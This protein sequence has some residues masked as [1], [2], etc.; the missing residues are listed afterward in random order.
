MAIAPT[1]VKWFSLQNEITLDNY[2]S[3]NGT[4]GLINLLDICLVN[5]KALP[6]ISSFTVTDEGDYEIVFASTH[7]TFLYQVVELTGFV[8]T[9]LNKEY[10]VINVPT[11]SSL[12]LSAKTPGQT[13]S[14][15]GNAKLA[16]LG[17]E[18]V[19]TQGDVKRVYRAKNP[20]TNHPYIRVDETL[21]DGTNTWTSTYAK[22]AAVG[23]IE[24]MANVDDVNDPGKLQLPQIYNDLSYNWTMAGGTGTGVMKGRISTWYWA[25]ANSANS[26]VSDVGAPPMGNRDWSI[27]GDK[28][29]FYFSRA[30]IASN[31]LKIISGCGLY[32]TATDTDPFNWF[33]ATTRPDYAAST[34]LNF[35]SGTMIGSIPFT[36]N[37]QRSKWYVPHVAYRTNDSTDAIMIGKDYTSGIGS[38]DGINVT[39]IEIP[40]YDNQN[41]VRGTM[42]HIAYSGNNRGFPGPQPITSGKSMYFTDSVLT[43]SSGGHMYYYLGE[44]E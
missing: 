27:V 44:W 16:P 4:G 20:A 29:A 23:L 9:E 2:W 37:L 22:C 15:I 28:D 19:Y 43:S 35:T 12:V 17:Y 3:T 21:T 5:G 39:A 33:L 18:I 24:D 8:P 6:G 14:N 7:S 25:R 1:N 36:Y 41:N 32:N 34:N 42:K 11:T 26:S 40:F 31:Q 38:I 13:Y 10:R 30:M